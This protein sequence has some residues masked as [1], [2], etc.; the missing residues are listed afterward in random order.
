LTRIF[1]NDIVLKTLP[2]SLHNI[3][4]WERVST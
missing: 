1:I 2:D 3:Y 4:G